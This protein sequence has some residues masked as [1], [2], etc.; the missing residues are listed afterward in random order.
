MKRTSIGVSQ[1]RKDELEK[2]KPDYMS[3]EDFMDK[4]TEMYEIKIPSLYEKSKVEK[5]KDIVNGFDKEELMQLQ[6]MQSLDEGSNPEQT[7]KA[8]EAV[9]EWNAMKD[10]TLDT[11]KFGDLMTKLV[12]DKLDSEW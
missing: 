1:K 3:W 2:V 8:K 4:L 6:E 10:E 9:E 12:R 11:E 5:F 7:R